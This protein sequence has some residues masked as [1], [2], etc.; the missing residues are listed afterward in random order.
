MTHDVLARVATP[1]FLRGIG[2]RTPA[3]R[4][5]LFGVTGSILAATIGMVGC[6]REGGAGGG[7]FQMPPTPVE[8]ATVERGPVADRFQTLGSIEAGDAIT[9][10]SEISGIVVKLPFGEGEPV[11]KGQPLAQLEDSEL[12]AELHRAEAVRD[13]E[14]ISHERIQAIVNEG[15]GSPQDLDDAAARFRVAEADL[16]LARARLAKTRITAPFDGVAGARRVSPGAFVDPGDAITDLAAF[17]EVKVSFYAPE[18][19][20]SLLAPGRSVTIGTPAMPDHPVEGT[21][22]VVE[23]VLDRGTRSLRVWAR[24]PNP[25]GRLRPG[26]SANVAATLSERP[27][28]LTVPAEAVFAEGNQF[29]VYLVKPDST[30]SRTVVSLGTR[31]TNV[32]E[33]TTGLTAGAQV[34]RAGH[35]KLYEGA[36]IFP[37]PGEA[38]AGA[39]DATGDAT[40]AG[41]THP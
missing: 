6:S 8:V 21:I 35:Q 37:L 13:Q 24:F 29:L 25:D 38:P 32:V 20:S 1:R 17:Q 23:P 33:V 36:R 19:Y 26:M 11:R 3:A 27:D 5:T 40:G 39:A 18:R 10:V 16:A 12:Q 41:A 15:A 31:L 22:S 14:K 9:V 28:A 7:G 4:G 2:P 30:V 34:V